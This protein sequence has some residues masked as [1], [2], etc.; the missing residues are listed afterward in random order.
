MNNTYAAHTM[1]AFSRPVQPGTTAS[2]S[3]QP[4]HAVSAV[5]AQQLRPGPPP[6]L[7]QAGY[8]R[9]HP[10]PPMPSPVQPQQYGRATVVAGGAGVEPRDDLLP[11]VGGLSSRRSTHHGSPPR[12]P[13]YGAFAAPSTTVYPQRPFGVRPGMDPYRHR[14]NT[15]VPIAFDGPVYYEQPYD[16]P[17]SQAYRYRQ[18]RPQPAA[19][20]LVFAVEALVTACFRLLCWLLSAP[21]R[22]AQWLLR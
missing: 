8:P 12:L 1:S 20:G 16:L 11:T 19:L 3:V 13:R 6:V 21:L 22:A 9:M 2:R 15:Q 10:A 18:H 5:P 7:H 14:V 4:R 17:A